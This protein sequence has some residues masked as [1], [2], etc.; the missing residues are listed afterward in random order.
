V[1]ELRLSAL[2]DR[3][4]LDDAVL[5]LHRAFGLHEPPRVI[6]PAGQRAGAQV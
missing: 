2:C 5:A 6:L 4:R 1:S 3:A